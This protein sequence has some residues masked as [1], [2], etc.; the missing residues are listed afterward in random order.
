MAHPQR[1]WLFIAGTVAALIAGGAL[2]ALIWRP[3]HRPQNEPP[4]NQATPLQPAPVTQPIVTPLEPVTTPVVVTPIVH[5]PKP[6]PKAVKAPP[7]RQAPPPHAALKSHTPDQVQAKF[8]TV[9]GEYAAFK[10]QYGAVLEDKWNAIATEITFGKADKFDKL[11]AMLDAL[12]REMAK[13]KAGG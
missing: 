11:D 4:A 1:R 10:S 13:V 3:S 2:A 12:R 5:H 9:K 8:R 6:H 7:P